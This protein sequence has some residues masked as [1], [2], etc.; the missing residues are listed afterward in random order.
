MPLVDTLIK[1]WRG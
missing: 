1:I